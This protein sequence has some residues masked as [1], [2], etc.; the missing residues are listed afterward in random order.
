MTER[1]AQDGDPRAMFTLGRGLA[2]SGNRVIGLW[3]LTRA[4][5]MGLVDAQI[6]LAGLLAEDGERDEAAWWLATARVDGFPP[7]D[8][9]F[10]DAVAERFGL[11]LPAVVPKTARRLVEQGWSV[12]PASSNDIWPLLAVAELE[13]DDLPR[14]DPVSMLALLRQTQKDDWVWA[15]A[16]AG[17]EVSPRLRHFVLGCMGERAAR[18]LM[19]DMLA[20]DVEKCRLR[21][22]DARHPILDVL[23]DLCDE[24]AVRLPD[25]L[26]GTLWQRQAVM[27]MPRD[28]GPYD[29][30]GKG[31]EFAAAHAKLARRSGRGDPVVVPDPSPP[32]SYAAT[33]GVQPNSTLRAVLHGTGERALCRYLSQC[34]A[35]TRFRFWQ[36]SSALVR[37]RL[38]DGHQGYGPSAAAGADGAM[39][40]DAQLAQWHRTGKIGWWE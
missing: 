21:I 9:G 4:A 30:G 39:A 25:D 3:W 34:P 19:R 35:L 33:L 5:E 17:D 22:A 26:A 12:V 6:R 32:G 14:L 7:V 37:G 23:C 27:P 13:F 18:L 15:L 29:F 20:V 24:G 28:G 11:T 38:V 8:G 1:A 2:E 40:M 36:V 16:P 31:R 10:G